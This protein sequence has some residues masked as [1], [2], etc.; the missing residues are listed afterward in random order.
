MISFQCPLHDHVFDIS[1]AL[2]VVIL[3]FSQRL[4]IYL[5]RLRKSPEL[6]KYLLQKSVN[7]RKLNE[8]KN[9]H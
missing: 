2:V 5:L 9:I 6:T 1:F 8:N 7:A 4:F 3:F